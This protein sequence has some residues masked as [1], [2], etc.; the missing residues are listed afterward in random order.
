LLKDIVPII[1]FYPVQKKGKFGRK[2]LVL[3]TSKRTVHTLQYGTFIARNIQL[4]DPYNKWEDNRQKI[5]K[6]YNSL[7]MKALVMGKK[8]FSSD[9]MCLVGQLRF[10]ENK[11]REEVQTFVEQ[12]YTLPMSTGT[13]SN[14]SL[15]F[16]IRFKLYH[17][18][19]FQNLVKVMKKEGGY[20]LGAD[21]TGDGGSNRVLLLIDLLKGWTLSASTIPTEKSD[22]I[23]PLFRDLVNKAGKPLSYVRDMGKGLRTAG[24]EVFSDIPTRECNFHFLRDVGKDLMTSEYQEFRKAFIATKIKPELRKLRKTL[25]H[26]AKLV[27]I[28]LKKTLQSLK[29]YSRVKDIIPEQIL[30]VETYHLISWI[31]NYS[32]DSHGLRF[33]YS[34]PWLYLNQRCRSAKQI[35]VEILTTAKELS[36]LPSYLKTLEKILSPV[37]KGEFTSKFEDL[38]QSLVENYNYFVRMRTILRFSEDKGD[39]PRDQLLLSGK[40]LEKVE[41]ELK[42]FKDELV[43]K[44]KKQSPSPHSSE[45]ILLT[46]IT[47]HWEYLIVPNLNLTV[48]GKTKTFAI[49]RAISL[50]DSRFGKIK[51]SIRRRT[52]KKDTGHEL[53]RYGVLLCYLENLHSPE[54]IQ[55]MFK[56]IDNMAKALETIP[57]QDVK[58]AIADFN[59]SYGCYDITNAS[60]E[61]EFENFLNLVSTVRAAVVET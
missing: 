17:D 27:G 55:I 45:Q 61:D 25:H 16:L 23:I 30:L 33:P 57:R 12:N 8:R 51:T 36:I 46:H 28:D 5:I 11:S 9:I 10:I 31:L 58:K 56:S 38:E 29:Q 4:Y 20:I 22:Y 32:E 3:K 48:N 40:E 47:H 41:E 34:L 52:G 35:L 54:Y 14:Y 53:N 59:T 1:D 37:F 19:H 21:G 49:P 39:I 43:Q 26:Q 50:A 7:V 6:K 13:I 60:G 15:E 18:L 2:L 24:E 42:K 44:V